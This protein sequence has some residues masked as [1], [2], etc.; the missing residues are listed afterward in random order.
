MKIIIV[1]AVYYEKLGGGGGGR[2]ERQHSYK[3]GRKIHSKETDLPDLADT[4][5]DKTTVETF[6]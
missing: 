5:R 3:G 2:V 4:V 1:C 6:H